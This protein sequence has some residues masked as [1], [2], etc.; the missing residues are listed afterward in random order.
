MEVFGGPKCPSELEISGRL[1]ADQCDRLPLAIVVVGGMLFQKF[2]A[3][4]GM[5]ATLNAWR[6]ISESVSM[7]LSEDPRRGMEKIIALSYDE[8]PYHLRACFLYL[9]MFPEDFEI[10]VRE[11]IRM[12][13]AEGFIQQKSSVSLE[14]I[15]ENYL[16]DLVNR[17]LV[18]VD[19]RKLD[20]RVKTC[21][22]HDMLRDFA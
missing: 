21:R 12:W 6:K 11:L 19:K 15:A 4:N 16:E 18:M 10:P 1:I 7:Y 13:V 20:G 2:S 8:L 22:I 14:E 5:V 17:N 3:S 9:G